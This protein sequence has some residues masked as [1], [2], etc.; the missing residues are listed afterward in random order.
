M[1]LSKLICSPSMGA[2]AKHERR[3]DAR[4]GEL[5]DAALELF[6]EKGFAATRSEEVAKR[7]GVSKG[8]LF[9]YFASKEELFKAVVREN[10]SGRFVEWNAEFVNFQGSTAD[11]LRYCM[12]AWWER[13]GSTKASGI[14]KLMMS[15]ARNFPDLATFYEHEVIQPGQELI[16]R[17]LQRGVDRG[18]FRPIDMKYGVYIVLA[19]M[20]FLAMWKHSLGT[21]TAGVQL[22][23]EEYLAVQVET[24]LYG[25]SVGPRSHPAS[26]EILRQEPMDDLAQ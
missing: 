8:T 9:L 19:P 1:P 3:K 6:V 15:E 17:V 7:A 23:P 4:P 13:I 18:E 21:C 26:A 10:I 12:T 16:Q 24:L 14:T 22:I 11:M 5:L 25:L 20:L 2:P